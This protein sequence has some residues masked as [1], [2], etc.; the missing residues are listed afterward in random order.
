MIDSKKIHQQRLPPIVLQNRDRLVEINKNEKY[1][2][3]KRNKKNRN[4]K[5]IEKMGS[6]RHLR[7]NEIRL[8]DRSEVNNAL[9]AEKNSN[10]K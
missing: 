1:E 4:Y 10:L 8:F 9:L 5:L 3:L 6:L 2:E 7:F